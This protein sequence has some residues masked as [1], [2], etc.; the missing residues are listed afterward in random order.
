MIWR[1]GRFRGKKVG[2]VSMGNMGVSRKV[3]GEGKFGFWV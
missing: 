1:L 3:V 2:E